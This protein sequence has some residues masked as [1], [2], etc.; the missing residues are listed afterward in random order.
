M[1][2]ERDTGPYWEAHIGYRQRCYKELEADQAAIYDFD[3]PYAP[4]R[5]SRRPGL[6]SA[7]F[8]VGGFTWK[9]LFTASLD[10]PAC[11]SVF[12]DNTSVKDAVDPWQCQCVFRFELLQNGKVFGDCSSDMHTFL[13]GKPPDRGYHKFQLL[14]KVESCLFSCEGPGG[15]IEECFTVRVSVKDCQTA[16][17]REL[18]CAVNVRETTGCMGLRNQGA[19][20]Y[21]NSLLQTLYH[22]TAFRKATYR[23]PGLMGNKEIGQQQQHQKNNVAFQL[24][25]LFFKIQ[26]SSVPVRTTELTESFGWTRAEAFEQ[27]DIQELARILLD[28]LETKMNKTTDERTIQHLFMGKVRKYVECR[29]IDYCSSRVDKFYDLQLQVKGF[30]TLLESLKQELKKEELIGENKYHCSD[31]EKGIDSKEDA[32]M[33]VEFLVLPPVLVMHLRRFE[34]DIQ[35]W[36]Y[37]KVNDSFSFPLHLDMSP[38]LRTVSGKEEQYNGQPPPILSDVTEE[39]WD[40]SL[41]GADNQDYQLHSVLVHSGYMHGGHYH[42]YIAPRDGSK[43]YKFDDSIV[44]PVSEDAAICENFGG[45]DRKRFWIEHTHKDS[46]AYMLVYVRRDRWEEVCG[47]P[48]ELP[49]ELASA[50]AAQD[51]AEAAKDQETRNAHLYN[52]FI[53]LTDE[54]IKSHVD[55]PMGQFDLLPDPK[56]LNEPPVKVPKEEV[57]I[58]TFLEKQYEEPCRIWPTSHWITQKMSGTG[59]PISSERLQIR[60]DTKPRNMV[61]HPLYKAPIG[62][63]PPDDWKLFF[64]KEYVQKE[65]EGS[66]C[67]RGTHF[68]SAS[69]PIT[70]QAATIWE[71]T[72]REKP[73]A[74]DLSKMEIYREQGNEV[75]RID[76]KALL[77]SEGWILVV[78]FPVVKNEEAIALKALSDEVSA[79]STAAINAAESYLGKY[80]IDRGNVFQNREIVEKIVEPEG[81]A[82]VRILRHPTVMILPPRCSKIGEYYDCHN[83]K[84]FVNLCPLSVDGQKSSSPPTKLLL[85]LSHSETEIIR[86]LAPHVKWPPGSIR[87]WTLCQGRKERLY[88]SIGQRGYSMFFEIGYELLD[89]SITDL[90]TKQEVRIPFMTAKLKLVSL[91]G[92]LVDHTALVSDVLQQY[93]KL[94][95][96]YPIE[97]PP[98]EGAPLMLLRI[99]NSRI[100]AE[101]DPSQTFESVLKQGYD[102]AYVEYR[103]EVKPTPRVIDGKVPPGQM[104]VRIALIEV[105]DANT[106]VAVFHETPFFMYLLPTDTCEDVLTAARSLLCLRAELKGS[107]LF[108]LMGDRVEEAVSP[109]SV[110]LCDFLR[111]QHQVDTQRVPSLGL[112]YKKRIFFPEKAIKIH[113]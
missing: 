83:Q 113:N 1:E 53:I 73:A 56:S 12:L 104:L 39:K 2:Y 33:G 61:L 31:E 55:S 71:M 60:V 99:R 77:Q 84:Q 45:K 47:G 22:L 85:S 101:V 58:D 27:H 64:L 106:G 49:S 98:E 17:N 70:S 21:L 28:N 15:I 75:S 97:D 96:T 110:I 51:E 108:S 88:S 50:F 42:A 4:F 25:R 79:P 93:N 41:A 78:V 20:C 32:D 6:Y 107:R 44:S 43:W 13:P 80:G 7:P 89:F 112:E 19:T 52:Y 94:L 109:S 23:L 72:G 62:P 82:A 102:H 95:H 16:R 111:Q 67:Y 37:E 9:V 57:H 86:L 54:H 30:K 105:K 35:T 63:Q 68:L 10:P 3:V 69:I 92:F 11:L 90:D 5:Q 81:I 91:P 74:E 38:F 59:T 48:S 103:V 29:N 26:T 65:F 36:Q 18:E 40:Q 100:E 8:K 66:L 14:E 76:D 34:Y 46:S 87:L 24:A